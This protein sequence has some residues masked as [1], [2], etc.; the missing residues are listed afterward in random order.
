MANLDSSWEASVV[1]LAQS[2]NLKAIT[3]WLN[4][5]LVPQGLCA[6]VSL[7]QPGG[8]L[9][10]V[11]CHRLPDGHRLIQ[12]IR[13]R[14]LELNS[15]VII[16][17]RITAQMVGAPQILWE[18]SIP[19]RFSQSTPTPQPSATSQTAPAMALQT[20]PQA[21]TEAQIQ[22]TPRPIPRSSAHRKSAHPQKPKKRIKRS[23]VVYRSTKPSRPL[24]LQLQRWTETTL[25]GLDDLKFETLRATRRSQQWLRQRSPETRAMLIGGSVAATLV[26]VCGLQ[27]LTQQFSSPGGLWEAAMTGESPSPRVDQS[28]TVQAVQE[29]V[30]V[31]RPAVQNPTDPA[32]TLI[33]AG[34]AALGQ[35]NSMVAYQQADLLMS[36]LDNS[37]AAPTP[38]PVAV[39]PATKALAA[40]SAVAPL[41]QSSEA[42]LPP[43]ETVA[44]TTP[45][46]DSASLL[47]A[48]AGYMSALEQPEAADVTELPPAHS[49]TLESL[50]ANGVDLVNVAT[51]RLMT[52]EA[53]LPQTLE[54][55]SQKAVYPVGAGQNQQE[56]RRPRIFEVKGQ[57]IAFLAYSDSDLRA[58]SDQSA[59][60]NPSVNPQVEADIKAIRDQVNWV[61][62]SYHWNKAVRSYPEEA[63]INMARAA[64]DHG[65]DLVVGYAPQITQGAEIYGGRPIIYSLGDTVEDE[66]SDSSS[67]NYHAAAL[68]VVL[69]DRTMNVELL[70]V[71][72]NQNRSMLAEGEAATRV[73]S[74]LRQASSLFDHPLRSPSTLD[75]RL[76]VSLPTAP[77]AEL[78]TNPFLR[79]PGQR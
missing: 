50:L 62:V 70:P 65:A 9:I 22:F 45:A 11:V 5:Y 36:N 71:Q 2:G 60:V 18:Q 75:A 34:N 7:E 73:N 24:R 58:A 29:R 37:L 66:Y 14:F 19:I 3:F 10:R 4:R 56:A 48:T 26:V 33:F 27:I 43:E 25:N 78:P 55:L 53:N 51:D 41:Q 16:T 47:V 20:V 74:Y 12:F 72:V 46:Q 38:S 76:R 1:K 44:S 15:E 8:L 54:L 28:G 40:K 63:Q 64:I 35:T 21:A 57:K 61:V 52:A 31:I 30:P 17:L 6:Q 67:E 77:D 68:K 42:Q 69:H 39:L 59:G 32:V 79:Y 49:T 23:S 13:Q